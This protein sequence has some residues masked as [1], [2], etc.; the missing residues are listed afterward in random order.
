MTEKAIETIYKTRFWHVQNTDLSKLHVLRMAAGV[1][2]RLNVQVSFRSV[3][4]VQVKLHGLR[5]INWDMMFRKRN[6]SG[7]VGVLIDQYR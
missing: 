3:F 4:A 5:E 6:D 2:N 1:P 7:V